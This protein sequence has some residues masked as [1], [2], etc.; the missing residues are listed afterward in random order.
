VGLEVR[1]VVDGTSGSRW[2]SLPGVAPG[3]EAW[4]RV[5]LG[6]TQPIS[7]VRLNWAAA[8]ASGYRV[9]VS[10]DD[11]AWT[12]V[13]ATTTGDGNVDDLLNLNASGRYVRVIADTPSAVAGPIAINDF[14][15]YA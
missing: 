3:A 12:D 14:N 8:F 10:N 7:R 1:N 5:D 4:V 6:R 11:A 15:V 9:Q 2:E 13:Y